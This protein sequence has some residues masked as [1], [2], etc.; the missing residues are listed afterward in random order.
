MTTQKTPAERAEAIFVST[1]IVVALRVMA[2]LAEGETLPRGGVV[3]LER[4]FGH[5]VAVRRPVA[6]VRRE[7]FDAVCPS[8]T[9]LYT[10]LKM[11]ERFAPTAP[12]GPARPL[13]KRWDRWLNERYNRKQ[14]KPREPQQEGLPLAQWPTTWPEGMAF[15]RRQTGLDL[16]G[17]DLKSKKPLA[18]DTLDA[19]EQAVSIYLLAFPWARAQGVF[20]APGFTAEAAEIF[21]RFARHARGIRLRSIVAYLGRVH[22]FAR[23]GLMMSNAELEGFSRILHAWAELA[24]EEEKAKVATLETFYAR[25]SLADIPRR[26]ATLMREAAALPAHR[27]RAGRLRRKGALFALASNAPE[28]L[29]DTRRSASV[30]AASAGTPPASGRSGSCRARPAA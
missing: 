8:R 15:L 17:T 10:L 2:A 5:L 28:R 30:P 12:L 1:P 13:R 3:S 23:R 18:P 20:V 6:Q 29:G 11:L 19:T 7:D 27:A 25:H 14:P 21:A 26:A 24:E 16:I 4:F 22:R 9:A